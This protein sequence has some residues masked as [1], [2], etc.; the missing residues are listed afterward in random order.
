[1]PSQLISPAFLN[2]IALETMSEPA[3]ADANLILQKITDFAEPAELLE[4]FD[5]FCRC[6]MEEH[7]TWKEG[8]P[9]NLLFICELFE[10]MVEACYLL[11]RKRKKAGMRESK[12][13]LAV[14]EFFRTYS[15][16]EWKKEFH[17]WVEAAFA[18]FSIVENVET[19]TITRFQ[20]RTRN[21]IKSL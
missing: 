20:V 9:G 4:L 13:D 17:A 1:M 7:Y 3:S 6:A 5:E 8:G 18:E 10:M 21:L 15:L 12:T 19:N 14:K 2:R 16:P 11:N